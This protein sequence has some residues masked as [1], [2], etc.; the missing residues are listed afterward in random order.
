MGIGCAV[1]FSLSI[2]VIW[3]VS[4]LL[5]YHVRVSFVILQMEF[6]HLIH[7]ISFSS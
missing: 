4:A 5:S 7:F 3:P 2:A 1:A 6:I